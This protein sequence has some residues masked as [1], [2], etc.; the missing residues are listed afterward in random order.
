MKDKSKRLTVVNTEKKPSEKKEVQQV[1]VQPSSSSSSHAPGFNPNLY[2]LKSVWDSVFEIKT[3]VSGQKYIFGKL[4]VVTKYGI[5][6]YAD[7]GNVDIPQLA[8]GLPYDQRT[9]WFNPETKQIEVIGGTGGGE[10]GV[11]NFWDLS[12]IPSWITNTKPT[13]S[14]S[15]ILGTPDLSAFI[16]DAVLGNTL[17]DYTTLSYLTGE[18]KK[19][20]TLDGEQDITGVKDFIN[21]LKIGGLPI[22]KKQD[23]VVY[24]DANLVVR[25]GI[26][27]YGDGE[28][29]SSIPSYS[30]LGSLLNVDES[31]DAVASV[32]RVLFQSAGSNVWSWKA[33]SEIG[34]GSSGGGSVSG[35]YLPLSGGTLTSPNVPLIINR[36]T[37][38]SFSLVGF[39][40]QSNDIGYLGFSSD[41]NFVVSP[42]RQDGNTTYYDVLHTGNYSSY[43]LPL[44]G[45][46]IKGLLS[47]RRDTS[48]IHFGNSGTINYGYLGFSGVDSPVVYMN[49]GTT[50]YNLLHSGNYS[51]YAL[52]L[53]GGT[54]NGTGDYLYV[55]LFVNA[56]NN[57]ISG[58]TFKTNGTEKGHVGYHYELGMR[59]HTASTAGIAVSNSD[60]PIF[61]TEDGAVKNTIL[62]SGNYSNYALPLSGGTLNGSFGSH[63]IRSTYNNSAGFSEYEALNYTRA[64]FANTQTLSVPYNS[65]Q[66]ALGW[67][68]WLSGQGYH[69]RYTISSIRF[70]GWGGMSLAVG[71]NDEGTYRGC[72]LELWGSGTISAGGNLTVSGGITMYSDQRKKTILGN[73]ELSL[74]DIAN[75]PLIEH[76]YNSDINKT[77][78]V[79]SIAQYWASMNDW[80]CKLDAE[81]YYTMEIQNC[82]L[83]SAISIARHLEKYE[84]K[85]D[86]TIRKMKKRIQE[87]EEEV[88]RL[89]QN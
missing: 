62:H 63:Y 18:L 12:G 37:N 3:D 46:T 36:T 86:K 65:V 74:K 13:Y 5:T 30:T 72:T 43:A 31:N 53:T 8:E 44:S 9:I 23:D 48:L 89:K 51:S 54:I 61:Y 28:G 24:L 10:S 59:L 81:G 58:I 21:G 50:K 17:A 15:E 41:G 60:V 1:I 82:A 27:M 66:V 35:D 38:G 32:D 56:L 84:S 16:T 39:Q 71:A 70:G 45:G 47:I 57:Q 64:W 25:G 68:N 67:S 75:A 52:P 26:T 11:S 83:A 87:L 85:T 77:T 20:V 7:D 29:G 69:T 78:H 49:N 4:P 22:T 14:Y 34:G 33:L 55:P 42:K 73:V 2:L 88:E 19:Y 40:S 80:F 76:Y 6:M 79:G